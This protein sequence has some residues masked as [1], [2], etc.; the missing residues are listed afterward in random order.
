[1]LDQVCDDGV[2]RLGTLC[3]NADACVAGIR[4]AD[5]DLAPVRDFPVTRAMAEWRQIDAGV[6]KTSGGVWLRS[7][8]A[9]GGLNHDAAALGVADYPCAFEPDDPSPGLAGEVSAM[10]LLAPLVEAV[11]ARGGYVAADVSPEGKSLP[12]ACYDLL[13]WRRVFGAELPDATSFFDGLFC[14]QHD[15][16]SGRR[17]PPA[18]VSPH[19]PGA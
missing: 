9:W 3:A 4:A 8:W 7:G 2:D 16:P 10:E 6:G 17:A 5:P 18:C 12:A 14:R 11:H 1:M 19:R 13:V 15:S